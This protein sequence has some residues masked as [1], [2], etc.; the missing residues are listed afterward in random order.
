[1]NNNKKEYKNGFAMF[2]GDAYA[3]EFFNVSSIKDLK[4]K[5]RDWLD[6][7]RL[8]NGT[9]FWIDNNGAIK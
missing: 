9:E 3:T 1:M 7:N 6:V 8:P 2:K 5:A 4:Q